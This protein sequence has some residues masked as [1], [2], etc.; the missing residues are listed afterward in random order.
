MSVI[1]PKRSRGF[2]LIELLVVVSIIALLISIL[3]PAVGAARKQA[4]MS[5]DAQ[6]MKQHGI[7]MSIFASQNNDAIMHPPKVPQTPNGA[8]PYGRTG[9]LAWRFGDA[10]F[11]TPAGF[12]F[13]DTIPSLFDVGAGYSFDDNFTFARQ[14]MF[15]AYWHVLA[16]YMVDG[17]GLGALQ[18]VFYSAADPEG[19]RS[20]NTLIDQ[21]QQNGGD[22]NGVLDPITVTTGEKGSSWRY[23]ATM[24]VDPC[25]VS[26]PAICAGSGGSWGQWVNV[27]LDQQE[28]SFYSVARIH[29]VA[30]M[31]FPSQKGVFFPQEAFYNPAQTYWFEPS[32]YSAVCMGDGSARISEVYN[33]TI[34]WDPDDQTGTFIA[35]LVPSGPNSEEAY[36]PTILCS[37]GGI[38]GRDLYAN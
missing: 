23:P 15:D 32:A 7:G 26:H 18:D 3:L 34:W 30:A 2:T 12:E 35:L 10:D 25:V 37:D 17:E 28:S 38:R 27:R 9:R 31:S 6:S 8:S 19:K 20:R 14:S 11:P 33:E 16:P 5:T 13:P 36:P 22:W 21:V 29:T 24:F 4:Y 1:T